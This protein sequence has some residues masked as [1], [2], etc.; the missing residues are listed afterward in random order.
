MEYYLK[1]REMRTLVK[2]LKIRMEGR[3]SA[4]L[5]G[6]QE[7]VAKIIYLNDKKQMFSPEKYRY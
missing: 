4:L 5:Q 7:K 1:G 3:K 6:K 2:K